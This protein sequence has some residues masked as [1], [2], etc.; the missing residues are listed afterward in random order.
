MEKRGDNTLAAIFIT[1]DKICVLDMN[2]E[3]AVCNVDASG[4]KKVNINKKG[5][6]KIEMIY[7]APMG[8]ILVHADDSLFLY[9]LAAKKVT[10]ELSLPEGLTVKQ[11][12]W[13]SNY[14]HFVVIAST[15]I[16]MVNKNLELL[17]SQSEP[18]KVKSGCFDE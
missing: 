2:R 14:T 6:T 17:I 13:T 11:I 12:H 10:A 4:L 5:L 16:M 1:K 15:R 8:K 18:C 9:D 3:L 7:P